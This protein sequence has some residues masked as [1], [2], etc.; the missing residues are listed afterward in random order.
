MQFV[1]ANLSK[2]EVQ[3][4]SRFAPK[5]ESEYALN[6]GYKIV[7][8][9]KTIEAAGPTPNKIRPKPE[10]P[11]HDQ[12]RQLGIDPAQADPRH[13][14]QMYQQI[15]YDQARMGGAFRDQFQRRDAVFPW[16]EEAPTKYNVPALGLA[17]SGAQAVT[18][19]STS[20]GYHYTR[21]QWSQT[22]KPNWHTPFQRGNAGNDL[23]RSD[24]E[25]KLP[26][27]PREARE[28]ADNFDWSL[29]LWEAD[30]EEEEQ[31]LD[32]A[33]I[34]PVWKDLYAVVYTWDLTKLELSALKKASGD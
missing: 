15:S 26:P 25:S 4:L 13:Y 6:A 5:F 27:V 16:Q 17:P 1:E 14:A 12:M 10:Q 29:L 21:G 9:S 34:V 20:E 31:Y 3:S 19:S 18:L 11:S 33:I 30:W 32:P 24:F 7:S 22:V 23:H 8:L 2:E 28:E